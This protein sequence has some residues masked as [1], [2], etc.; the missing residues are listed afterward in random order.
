MYPPRML[1]V[2]DLLLAHARLT[3]VQEFAGDRI[4]PA[5]A[6][7]VYPWGTAPAWGHRKDVSSIEAQGDT[8]TLVAFLM[9]SVRLSH[10]CARGRRV[11]HRRRHRSHT[12]AAMASRSAS[13]NTTRPRRHS[14]PRQ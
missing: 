6:R 1:F 8:P 14:P 9:V 13:V 10:L 12:G 3:A 5:Q 11:V 4:E 7:V 2:E